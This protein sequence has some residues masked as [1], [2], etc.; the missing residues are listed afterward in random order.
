MEKTTEVLTGRFVDSTFVNETYHEK[1]A[2]YLHSH[3]DKLE[4]LYIIEGNGLYYV[5]KHEYIVN[6]GNMVICNAGIT[7]GESPLRNNRMISYCCVL[8]QVNAEGM[9]AN[10]LTAVEQNPILYFPGNEVGYVMQAIHGIYAKSDEGG[11]DNRTCNLLA[12]ALLDIV[13]KRILEMSRITEWSARKQGEFISE[14]MDYL[15]KN[16]AEPITL[17]SVAERFHMSQ[18]AFSRFF[19]EEAG[20]SPLKYLL[21]RRLGEA[22]SLL[23]NTDLSIGEVGSMVGYYDSSHFSATFRKH[24]GLTPSQ[25]R[26]HFLRI[27]VT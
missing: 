14:I 6:A 21:C 20:I 1:H 9:P 18:S 19:K 17:E 26:N 11:V 22:Q 23:M 16:Y 2:H 12:N 10:T 27:R 7:H 5:N 8:D 3:R 4:L 15:D 25:Y 13:Y 24:T